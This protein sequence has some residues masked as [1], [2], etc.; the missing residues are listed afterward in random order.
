VVVLFMFAVVTTLG[1]SGSSLAIWSESGSP[2]RSALLTGRP[3]PIR[4]DEWLVSSPIKIGQVRAGFPSKRVF[5]MGTIDAQRTWRSQIPSRSAGGALFAPYNLPLVLLP[6]SH[7][8]AAAWWLPFAV[9]ALALYAWLRLMGVQPGVALASSLLVTSAPACVWWSNWAVLQ[10]ACAA[11]PSALLVWAVRLWNYR[12]RAALVVG[13]LSG[14]SAAPLP[15]TYQPWAI[16][17]CLFTAAV[18]LLWA[19]SQRPW[20]RALVFVGAAAG[21]IFA[22]E[23]L[24]YYLHERSYYVALGHT[25][26]PGARRFAGGGFDIGLLFSSLFPFALAGPDGRAL[27]QSNLSEVS[28]GWTIAL[29][30]A[31]GALAFG[32]RQLRRDPD[33]AVL[34]G[35]ALVAVVLSSWCLVEWPTPLAKISFMTF[36]PPGRTAP[37]IGYFGVVLLALVLG[38]PDRRAALA[39]TLQGAGAPAVGVAL[40]LLAFY[41]AVQ[42]QRAY[43]PH[44]S[45]FD[46]A[47]PVFVVGLLTAILLTRWSLLGLAF[48]AGLSVLSAGA[49]N[50]LVHGLGE[51]RESHAAQLVRNI[52]RQMVAP[53]QGTWASDSLLANGLL[54]GQGVNSLSSFND[55]VSVTGWRALDATSQYESLWNRFARIVFRWTPGKD[56]KIEAPQADLVLVYVDPCDGR[57]SALRLQVVLAS[58]PLDEPCLQEI[59]RLRWQGESLTLYSRT[60]SHPR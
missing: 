37:M 41:G 25:V 4:S 2:D 35:T 57:L 33:R 20:R 34:Y 48:A 55:P 16:P 14:L 29:P 47:L 30:A 32:R 12:P 17:V 11:V 1:I 10:I 59:D 42:F 60:P 46:V 39:K 6:P 27:T 19:L 7:G 5:G 18:T 49:V 26:Y 9:G 22:A 44:L 56:L 50:P 8:F 36:S 52:D 23:S 21:L 51:L 54:N 13:A 15:W 58:E 45:K 43:L 31:L 24:V 28:M 53:H 3:L 38:T 40:S